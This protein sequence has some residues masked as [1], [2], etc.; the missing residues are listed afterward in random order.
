MTQEKTLYD[1]LEVSTSA[2]TEAI[3][4]AFERLKANYLEGTL[5]SDRLD[6]D[7]HFNLIK[8]AFQTLSNPELRARY[9]RRLNPPALPASAVVIHES[10]ADSPHTLRWAAAV[11]V[12]CV[13]G[14]WLYFNHKADVQRQRLVAEAIRLEEQRLAQEAEARAAETERDL[15]RQA[16]MEQQQEEAR[17]RM[18]AQRVEQD[19][20]IARAQADR[21]Y[22]QSDSQQRYDQARAEREALNAQRR[23]QYEEESRRRREESEAR[24][25]LAR[26]EATLRQLERENHRGSGSIAP[27]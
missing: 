15:A 19:I 22:N 11:V 12:A 1:L 25:R 26:D 13:L 20:R 9:D 24:Y 2:S 21:A 5:R 10:H 7:T 14:A 27:R 23:S 4:A 16:R 17:R 8:D 18:E 3:T 6:P